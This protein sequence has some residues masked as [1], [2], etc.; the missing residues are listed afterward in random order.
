VERDPRDL[1]LAEGLAQ[2]FER[3]AIADARAEEAGAVVGDDRLR[4]IRAPTVCRLAE[5][6]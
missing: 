3:H 2:V 5:V 6:L 4:P 1:L